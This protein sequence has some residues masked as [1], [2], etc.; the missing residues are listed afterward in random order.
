MYFIEGLANGRIAV[1]GKIH[2]ALADGVASANLLA[3]GMDL[4]PG[5]HADRDSYATDPV[6]ARSELVRSAFA[7]HIR[8]IG[9]L[10]GVVRYTAQGV[11]RVRNSSKK[12]SA[13]LTRPF[14]PPPSF[15]NHRVDA[16]RMFATATLALAD[17]KE[18][19]GT[20]A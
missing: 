17:A 12:L 16:Q 8:Q 19:P 9:R 2:H 18:P 5:A 6:P 11:R 15:M 4:R 7:D 3:R 14:T 10:P 20:S 13:E 1:L